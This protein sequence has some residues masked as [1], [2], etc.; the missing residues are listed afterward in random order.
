MLKKILLIATAALIITGC[1]DNKAQEKT[2]LNEVI[3]IHDKV[4]VD[5]GVVMQNKTKLKALTTNNPTPG[6][7]DSVE[8]YSK[9]LNN[10]DDTMMTW[11]NKFNPDFTGKSHDEVM[12]Y[13]TKQK[14]QIIKINAQLDTA[15][16]AS[17]VYISKNKTK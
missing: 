17:N 3:K 6:V 7:K 11:M 8:M 13:L 14:A 2:L 4:M 16:S 1:S 15:I 5:D 9:L 12:D 10:A